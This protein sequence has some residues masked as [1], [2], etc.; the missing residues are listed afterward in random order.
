LFETIPESVVYQDAAGDI[1]D[2]NPAA[3]QMKGLSLDEL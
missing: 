2:A 1:T 3:R